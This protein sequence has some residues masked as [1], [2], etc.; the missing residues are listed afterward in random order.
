MTT[1][2]T[3]ASSRQRRTLR[4]TIRGMSFRSTTQRV[5]IYGLLLVFAYFCLYSIYLDDLYL[6]QAIEP[7]LYMAH[8]VDSPSG[9]VE[10]LSRGPG[11]A[12]FLDVDKKHALCG[13][14]GR[15]R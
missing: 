5:I 1:A 3:Q 13:F 2:D 7:N 11:L 6:A 9:D 15:G 12:A 4:A 14:H 8:R 10:Q